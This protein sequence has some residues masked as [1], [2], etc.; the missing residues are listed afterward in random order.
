MKKYSKQRQLIYNSLKNR[1]DHPTV[2]QLYEDLKLEMPKL[3]IATVYRN[4]IELCES[5]EVIKLKSLNGPD[6][7]DGNNIPHIH[8]ECNKCNALYDIFLNEND[9]KNM[10]NNINDMSR[11]IG[12]KPEKYFLIITGECGNCT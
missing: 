6:R 5:G 10:N 8:F 1:T 3:G 12:A 7:Y 11:L 4:L 2:E 9:L